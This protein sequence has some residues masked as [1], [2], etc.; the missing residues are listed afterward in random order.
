MKHHYILPT[1]R[2]YKQDWPPNKT[3]NDHQSFIELA[4]RK[5][6]VSDYPSTVI[7]VYRFNPLSANFTKWS[8]TLKQFVGNLPTN[9]LSV[10]GHFVGLVLKGSITPRHKKNLIKNLSSKKLSKGLVKKFVEK[11]YNSKNKSEETTSLRTS[12]SAKWRRRKLEFHKLL[13]TR[14]QLRKYQT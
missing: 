7:K 14:E 8:N 2:K 9:C 11:G 1:A 12:T 5:S 4:Y 3:Q 6:T 10:F 13:D